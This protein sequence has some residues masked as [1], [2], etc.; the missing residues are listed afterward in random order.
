MNKR[1]CC[2][3]VSWAASIGAEGFLER[4][5]KREQAQEKRDERHLIKV[6]LKRHCPISNA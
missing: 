4:D 5:R 3:H 1:L 2:D 6:S